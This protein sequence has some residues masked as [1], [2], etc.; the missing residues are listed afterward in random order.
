M[1]F[2]APF[3]V[4]FTS[5]EPYLFE[6]RSLRFTI[7]SSRYKFDKPNHL[8]IKLADSEHHPEFI[9]ELLIKTAPA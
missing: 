8:A 9:Q 4:G 1:R 6:R 2:A 5:S 3:F 7:F